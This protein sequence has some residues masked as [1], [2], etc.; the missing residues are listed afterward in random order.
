[1]PEITGCKMTTNHVST[2]HSA[3]R[4]GSRTTSADSQRKRQVS[5]QTTKFWLL[6]SQAG[7]CLTAALVLSFACSTAQAATV[8]TDLGIIQYRA[9]P[10]EVNHL[11]VTSSG[12]HV[13]IQDSVVIRQNSDC[14]HPTPAQRRVVRC[15][16]N[17][18]DHCSVE[19]DLGDRNDTAAIAMRTPSDPELGAPCPEVADGPGNDAVSGPR[20]STGGVFRPLTIKAGPG[21]DVYRRVQGVAGTGAG[22]DAIYGTAA[23]DNL[24][25]G[26]G[27]DRIYGEGGNDILFGGAGI[28]LLYGGPGL[29][30]LDGRMRDF[31]RG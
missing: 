6:V 29:D 13:L 18:I 14:R 4:L 26:L 20:S 11:T 19:I 21:K 9:A 17:W 7:V 24:R 27:N 1:M 25:G 2:D 22:N 5:T 8:N 10:G 28:D 31:V 12:G 30:R 16:W 23:Y 15:A 3:T